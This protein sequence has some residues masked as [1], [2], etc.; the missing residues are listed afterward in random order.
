M[1]ITTIGITLSILLLGCSSKPNPENTQFQCLQEGVKAPKWTCVP[2]VKGYYSGVGI[3]Q[4]SKA[5]YGFMRREA[6]MNGRSDLAQQINVQ[7]KNRIKGFTQTTGIGTEETVDKV[8]SSV[9]D[10][11]AKVYLKSS[12]LKNMWTAPSGNL[13]VLVT[14]P[15]DKINQIAENAAISSYKN[16][17]AL[18]QQFQAK[19]AFKELDTAFNK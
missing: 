14:I 12:K 1:K 7:I 16:N 8:S 17:N 4:K 19:N 6:I 13:Y 10:Q 15:N 5:G 9:T 11:L 18:W 3:A 2:N